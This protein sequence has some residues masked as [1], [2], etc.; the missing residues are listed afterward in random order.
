MAIPPVEPEQNRRVP[1]GGQDELAVQQEEE[2]GTEGEVPEQEGFPRRLWESR[3][4]EGWR[5]W[6]LTIEIWRDRFKLQTSQCM[7]LNFNTDLY[8]HEIFK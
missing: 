7:Y 5:W 6:H 2:D 3:W 4:V 1:G 8:I